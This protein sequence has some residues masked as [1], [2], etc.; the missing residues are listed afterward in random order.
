MPK[1]PICFVT[2]VYDAQ[3]YSLG[4]N[5]LIASAKYFHPEIPF[6]ILGTEWI[7]T[8]GGGMNGAWFPKS[9]LEYLDKYGWVVHFDADCI[10]TGALTELM[11]AIVSDKYDV[12]TVR[13]NNDEGKA[14][15]GPAITQPGIDIM[16]YANTG[17]V[18]TRSIQFAEEWDRHNAMY[19]DMVPFSEQSTFN[20]LR[21][22]FKSLII[23][24]AEGNVYYG[25]SGLYGNGGENQ[26]H[27]DSWKRIEVE[28]GQLLLNNKVIKIVHHAGG[29][30]EY[31]LG[32]HMF[33]EDARKRII[34]ITEPD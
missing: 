17:L 29:Y 18:A 34:E 28:A 26:S 24:P 20:A 1:E 6:F 19:A 31:K 5:R 23:D 15:S 3:Y 30:K 14:A 12:I 2:N 9:L 16:D 33:S 27:W 8:K 4:A 22:Y 7:E 10:I 13:N 25:V 32:L 11:E 21:K